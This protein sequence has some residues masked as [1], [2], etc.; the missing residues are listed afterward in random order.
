MKLG[1]PEL[2]V[3]LLIVVIL[4][5]HRT[6]PK[7]VQSFKGLFSKKNDREKSVKTQSGKDNIA[8]V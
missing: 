7:L 1:L 6:I 4:F 2:L 8:D 5:G 3:I